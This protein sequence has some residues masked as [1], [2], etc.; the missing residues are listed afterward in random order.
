M[1]A[2]APGPNWNRLFE[3]AAAQEGYFTT[4]QAEE[5]GYSLPL[6]AKYL[7][8][9]RVV[10]ARR[11]VY[12]LVHFPAGE[13]EDLVTVWLWSGR[14]GVFSHETAL[15]L[16][17]LSDVLP[18]RIHLTLPAAWSKR[19]FRVP[20]GVG[21]HYGDV[22]KRERAWAGSVPVTSPHRT[23]VDVRRANLSPEFVDQATGQA[24]AR[25]LINKKDAARL[26]AVGTP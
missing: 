19:R 7:Q 5:S 1:P 2:V 23:L 3:T 18:S 17:N 6:L 10:R 25:G 22:A 21:L 4:A 15:S 16:H 12:R 20:E 8:N 13:H 26:A 14:E 24:L 11:G 9:G